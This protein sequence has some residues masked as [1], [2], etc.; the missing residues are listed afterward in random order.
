MPTHLVISPQGATETW[1]RT[2]AGRPVVTTQR[3][4][5]EGDL[6]ERFRALELRFKLR[7]DDGALLYTQIGAT[8]RWG[9]L[10]LPL[11]SWLAP[12]VSAREWRNGLEDRVAVSVRINFPCTH[13]LILYEGTIARQDP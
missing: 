8:L 10:S 13:L 1:I 3:E 9:R 7:V 12:Q 2:F 6:T 5:D 4:S 11:P